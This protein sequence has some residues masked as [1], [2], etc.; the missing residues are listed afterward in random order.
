MRTDARLDFGFALGGDESGWQVAEVDAYGALLADWARVD[1]GTPLEEAGERVLLA[2][3]GFA[4][5]PAT[6]G[7]RWRQQEEALQRQGVRIVVHGHVD[8]PSYVLAA[9]SIEAER[10]HWAA[11]DFA[12]LEARA[13]AEDWAGRLRAALAALGLTPAQAYPAWLLAPCTDYR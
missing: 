13:R 4:P 12:E 2:A 1:D 9:H 8:F 10:G 3:A 6:G 7:S 5:D 11:V